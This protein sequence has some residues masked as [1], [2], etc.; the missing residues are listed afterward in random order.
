MFVS[1]FKHSRG[2][3]VCRAILGAL[4]LTVFGTIAP[5]QVTG[6][7]SGFVKDPTGAPV[8]AAS[9]SARM[10]EQQSTHAAR[11]NSEGFYDLLALPP[12]NYEITFE[13]PGFQRQVRSGVELTINQNLRVDA[14]LEVGSVDTQVT[15]SGTAPLVDTTSPVLSGLIDDRRVVDLPINGRNIMSLAGILPGV[16]GVAVSQNMDNARS[17][18]VMNVNGGRSNMNLFTFNGAYFNNPSRNTGINFPPPD[19]IEEVR[20]LT[21]D[22]SA[23]YGHNPGS[24]VMVAS[25]A[26]ANQIHGAA[27][28]FLRN[29]A[30]NARNFFA[31]TVP[32]VHQHQFGGDAGGP[33]KKDRLFVFGAYQ[34]LINHQQAQ[35]VQAFVPTAAQRGGDF[36]S[37]KTTLVNPTDP[38][39]GKPLLDP[40]GAPCVAGNRIAAGCISPAATKLLG[41]VPQSLNG[42]LVTLAAS[43]VRG[44]LGMGRV[45]WN[46]SDKHRIFGSYFADRNNRANPLAGSGSVAGYM[47][48]SYIESTDSVAVNDV[49][50]FSPTLLNQGTFSWSKINSSQVEDLK[51]NPTDLGINIPQYQQGGSVLINVNGA[52]I[53][54]SGISSAFF[55]QNWQAKDTLSWTRGK[56][57]IKFGYEWLHTQFEQI[58]IGPPNFAFTGDA[59]GNATADFLLGRFN[60]G[61]VN[62]GI[63]DTNVHTDFHSVFFQD[64]FKA[65]A[66]LTLTYGIRFEPFLPWKEA[67]DRINSVRPNQQ[68]TVVP[69]APVGI[70]F[71]GDKGITKGID[72]PDLNNFGPRLG[73]AWDVF[74][75][76]RTSVRAGYG[77]F[78]ESINADSLAQANAPYAGTSSIFGG[79]L[80]NP[81]GSLGLT[82]PPTQTSAAFGCSKIA[83]Y[84]GYACPLF[85]LPINGGL[86]I[87]PGLRS[88]YI[89]SF[90][91]SIQRQV[92]SSVLVETT[93]AGKIGAKLEALRTFNPAAFVNSPLT[94]QAPSTQNV[95]ER[96]LYEPGILGAQNYLLGNDFRSTYHSWQT[97]VTKRM[98]RGFTVL[99]SYTLAKSIDSSST[100]NLGGTVSDP[101]D[102]HT[103]RGRSTWDRRNVFVVSW[104]WNTPLR[105]SNKALNSLAGGWTL[106]GITTLQSGV[107]L[108]FLMGSDV[109][110]D[111]TGG[112]QHAQLAPGATASNITVSH[113]DR[114][115]FIT[116]FFNTNEFVQPRLVPRG[117]YG[118]AG[119]GL[120]SGPAS[121]NTD[122]AALKDFA[123]RETWKL[124]FR[125]EFFNALN[126]V[127][128]GNP[129]QT[130]S[131]AAFGRITS[132]A[133]GRVIQLALKLIW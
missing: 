19:A 132:A 103:E 66:R 72:S 12:G 29:D 71:P 64:E 61:T 2:G 5:A 85:P 1:F 9:V 50:T 89:Q 112:S 124:Q 104:L 113:P 73:L 79:L 3:V 78:F 117:V 102:L 36:T 17:G 75:N 42:T 131:S 44:D 90:N 56:H 116:Q 100:N 118:N 107:P 37:L 28:E 58:F 35:S 21:H 34:G 7:I 30:F 27:W 93:Y 49:Y 91:F 122:L 13:A 119:R 82:P 114:N 20:I 125:G 15:V 76:G 33:I 99:G 18:P 87:G 86:F 52:F 67:K 57:Q 62:F 88:P 43:P 97:Q 48:E 47:S 55:S 84:P 120:I 14:G 45:D 22:F 110:L 123:L 25:K 121:A 83:A 24:Q 70:V 39:T 80:D 63:R 40:T 101:F 77:I 130:V 54:G 96:V 8:P 105:F 129:N 68:S 31:P 98:S 10:T 127:N 92:T 59:T 94:G 6:R 95:N 74:G 38:I 115:A 16:V 11:T 26:G 60:T 106:T 108:T 109:A 32:A 133:S 65:H 46:Q 128:F 126:Q 81:Y 69:D 111:G 53:L 23:E 41:F 4:L 51:V